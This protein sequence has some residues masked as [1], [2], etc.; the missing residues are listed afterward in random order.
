MPIFP[1]NRPSRALAPLSFPYRLA[2]AARN[3]FYD[4]EL[5]PICR[6]NAPVISIGNLTVGGT[7]KTP[8]VLYL[9]RHL[10]DKGK[11]VSI[12]TRGY[13]RR[14]RK[15][16]VVL[17]GKDGIPPWRTVGDE[18]ALMSQRLPDIDVIVDA[19]RCRS[20]KYATETLGCDAILLDD[21]FQHR[22]LHR[23]LDIVL[24]DSGAPFHNGYLLPAGLL[25]ESPRSLRRSEVVIVVGADE[26]T[27]DG[28]DE[29]LSPRQLL[30]R[31]YREPTG[32]VE[33]ESGSLSPKDKFSGAAVFAFA[34]IA[35][36]KGLLRTVTSMGVEVTQFVRFADHQPYGERELI[37]LEQAWRASGA[38]AL[39]TTEKDAVRL[40]QGFASSLPVHALR[41]DFRITLNEDSLIDRVESLFA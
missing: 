3:T 37:K 17:R 29:L 30:C 18:P 34:G 36:A 41:I 12:L 5:L 27:G 4:H 19:D 13:G 40:P 31:A 25:R 24:L 39:I 14:G 28:F 6:V 16:L 8:C 38:S 15:P 33:L 32:W 10:V 20:A 35:D 22:Q 21:G 7:G 23:N 9:A 2:V 1:A 26:E 11:R